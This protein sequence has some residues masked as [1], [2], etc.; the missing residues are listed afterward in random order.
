M[1]T[2]YQ[3]RGKRVSIEI[4]EIP[5]GWRFK[6]TIEKPSNRPRRSIIL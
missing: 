3:Y 4:A 6:V 1:K 5:E 2:E